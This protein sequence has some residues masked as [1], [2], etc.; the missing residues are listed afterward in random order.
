[1]NIDKV[2]KEACFFYFFRETLS[3]IKNPQVIVP[4]TTVVHPEMP[5]PR[6]QMAVTP[7]CALSFRCMKLENKGN[8]SCCQRGGRLMHCVPWQEGEL[9]WRLIPGNPLHKYEF[10][11]ESEDILSWKRK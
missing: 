11:L 6:Q 4:Q 1:M 8:W 2:Y 7:H 3:S 9:V 10:G 5:A